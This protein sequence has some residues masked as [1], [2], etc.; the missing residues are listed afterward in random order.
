VSRE[1]TLKFSSSGIQSD[2]YYLTPEILTKLESKEI[3][4]LPPIEFIEQ[5]ADKAFNLSYGIC[6]D[7]ESFE[8]HLLDGDRE[9]KLEVQN[10]EEIDEA[11]ED[12]W[13]ADPQ[14]LIIDFDSYDQSLRADL[15]PSDHHV[16]A[17][18]NPITYGSGSIN[19]IL[20]VDDD[21]C[22]SDIRLIIASLDIGQWDGLVNQEIYREGLN[23][24]D[25]AESEIYGLEYKGIRYDFGYDLSFSGGSGSLTLYTYDQDEELW[26]ANYFTDIFD[27]EDG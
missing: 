7:H 19:C 24:L 22:P 13:V 20:S 25:E 3:E 9:E 6:Y 8:V 14:K 21:F 27:E 4:G 16:A 12:D 1:I 2:I 18:F 5:Y 17:V 23:T 26:L 11:G 15:E 10:F